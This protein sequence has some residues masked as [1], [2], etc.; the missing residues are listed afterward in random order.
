[1]AERS[2]NCEMER[3]GMKVSICLTYY[4]SNCVE[5]L[6]NTIKNVSQNSQSKT[7]N[8][9][10]L[11]IKEWLLLNHIYTYWKLSTTNL[12]A[13]LSDG[14]LCYNGVFTECGAAHKVVQR[15]SFECKASCTIRHGTLTLKYKLIFQSIPAWKTSTT[16][17]LMGMTGLEVCLRTT[18]VARIFPQRFVFGDMQNLQSPHWGMYKGITWSPEIDTVHQSTQCQQHMPKTLIFLWGLKLQ[19]VYKTQILIMKFIIPAFTAVTPSP[20]LSTI[21]PPSCPNTH[22]KTPSGSNPSKV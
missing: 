10:I 3:V 20:T 16:V 4:P 18:W 8:Q 6:R 1:M 7:R 14:N 17:N 22:G 2:L 19:T 5:K 12:K 9:Y 15:S 13:D 21:P 11:N